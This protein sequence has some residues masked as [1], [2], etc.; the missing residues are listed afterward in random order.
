MLDRQYHRH[1][2]ALDGLLDGFRVASAPFRTG[3]GLGHDLRDRALLLSAGPEALL[4]HQLQHNQKLNRRQNQDYISSSSYRKPELSQDT[5]KHRP[6]T[7]NPSAFALGLPSNC[8][9]YVDGKN[10]NDI[11]YCERK[12]AR[13]SKNRRSESPKGKV[14]VFSVHHHQPLEKDVR[15]SC[16][17]DEEFNE[18]SMHTHSE[19]PLSLVKAYHLNQQVDFH[20]QNGQKLRRQVMH[21]ILSGI[22]I[23]CV[24]AL[25]PLLV[26]II[27]EIHQL[28]QDTNHEVGFD[29]W[30]KDV[31]LNP[32]CRDEVE[33]QQGDQH[34][35]Q[36]LPFQHLI[37]S[38]LEEDEEQSFLAGCDW[39]ELVFHKS[40][41]QVQTVERW[42]AT[43]SDAIEHNLDVARKASQSLFE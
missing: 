3:G 4:N 9:E 21:A 42:S 16:Q 6:L 17:R 11:G 23:R 24:A 30:L 41:R 34:H 36:H 15:F 39:Q 12:Q 33:R 26:I 31:V 28:A 27:L 14:D 10:Q 2:R 7:N 40:Q 5:E 1:I 19:R 32:S 25:A 43:L 35:H 22:E 18:Y 8:D 13:S 29:N 37:E 38:L 20:A